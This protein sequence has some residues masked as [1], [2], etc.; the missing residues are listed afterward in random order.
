MNKTWKVLIIIFAFVVIGLGIYLFVANINDTN[1]TSKIS[2]EEQWN[3]YNDFLRSVSVYGKVI[4]ISG[5]KIKILN[6][7][8]KKEYDFNINEN[9]Y[10]KQLGNRNEDGS[11]EFVDS[12]ITKITID[13][14]VWIIFDEAD[15]S[16]ATSIMLIAGTDTQSYPTPT[17]S[18]SN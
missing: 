15:N 11:Q 2:E 5:D 8:D 17:L 10:I 1:N 9:T 6:N 3:Q 12:D 18:P 16:L 13:E 7:D 14:E 4:E